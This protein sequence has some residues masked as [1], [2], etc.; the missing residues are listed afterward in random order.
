MEISNPMH[1]AIRSSGNY[2]SNSTGFLLGF[3][4]DKTYIS[5]CYGMQLEL[6]VL[7]LLT[8]KVKE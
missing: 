5:N 2:S 1:A 7:P 3:Q 4:G 6:S 8:K